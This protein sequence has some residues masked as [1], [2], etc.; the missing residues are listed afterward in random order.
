MDT[1]GRVLELLLL[2][3]EAWASGGLRYPLLLLSAV[4]PTTLRFARSQLEWMSDSMARA[5]E[6]RRDNPFHLRFVFPVPSLDDCEFK[7]GRATPSTSGLPF[8]SPQLTFA[9]LS[10]EV[11][12]LPSRPRVPC[13]KTQQIQICPLGDA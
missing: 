4:A 5:F 6:S 12:V 13:P 7:A 8:L 10:L 3:E 9:A 11:C 1:A 2:L